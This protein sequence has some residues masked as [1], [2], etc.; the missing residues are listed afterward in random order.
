MKWL[1]E[2][3]NNKDRKVRFYDTLAKEL[4]A[5]SQNQVDKLESFET[6]WF[7]FN[8]S[9]RTYYILHALQGGAVRRKLELHKKCQENRAYAHFR[10]M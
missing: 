9:K 7:K 1:I 3:A 10:W 5:A 8:Y 4:V 2:A 6:N